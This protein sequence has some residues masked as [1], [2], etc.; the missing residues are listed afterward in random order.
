LL[1]NGEVDMIP[2]WADMTLDQKSR[3][4]LPKSI[5]I[6]QI[7]PA[8]TGGIQTLVIPSISKNKEAAYK[9][10]DFVASPEGQKI[11]VEKMKAIP[12]ID[13]SLLSKDTLDMLSGLDVKKLRTYTIGAL[14][15]ELQ[16]RW[17]SEIATL[18]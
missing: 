16:K 4:L 15:R 2:A 7:D 8:F 5:K 3:G 9:L 1:A 11:F 18:N 6:T 17:Q 12:V 14:E 13:T 10:L